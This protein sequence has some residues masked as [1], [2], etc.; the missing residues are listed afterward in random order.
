MGHALTSGNSN[1]ESNCVSKLGEKAR[2]SATKGFAEC[3]LRKRSCYSLNP[4]H[5]TSTTLI[6]LLFTLLLLQ[7]RDALV[8]GKRVTTNYLGQVRHTGQATRRSFFFTLS[9][10]LPQHG[11]EQ[12]PS[13]S[14]AASSPR[15]SLIRKHKSGV[16]AEKSKSSGASFRRS[17]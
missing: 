14:S 1:Q 15:A 13:M 9:R 16:R 10:R 7:S 12:S 2:N 6:L 4:T 11:S 8:H 3:A 5:R 17:W